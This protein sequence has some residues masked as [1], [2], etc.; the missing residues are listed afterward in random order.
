MNEQNMTETPKTEQ[1]SGGLYRKV[2]I[3]LKTANILVAVVVLLLI[4]ALVFAVSHQGF[5][6]SFDTDGGTRVNSVIVMHG[7]LLSDI[8]EPTR[9]GFAFAGW[10]TDAA[11]TSPWDMETPVTGSMKLYAK[12]AEKE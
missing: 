10:Y 8:P 5:T 7:D 9:E 6:V 2:N 12:W 4:G 11:C 3:S 1:K